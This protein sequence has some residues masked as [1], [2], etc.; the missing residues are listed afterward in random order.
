MAA[1]W[2]KK[3]LSD[4]NSPE[5]LR[6]DYIKLLL[7]A[8]QRKKLVGIFSDDAAHYEKLEDFPSEFDVS[9][10]IIKI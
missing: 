5:K 1:G 4:E 6:I 7:F 8:L 2:V 9:C 10:F 3:I